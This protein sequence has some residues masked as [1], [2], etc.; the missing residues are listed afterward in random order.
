MLSD[1]LFKIYP[2]CLH[3]NLNQ[4]ESDN[5]VFCSMF[6]SQI[7]FK[8][9][10][11]IK[12]LQLE[13]E[14]LMKVVPDSANVLYKKKNT[15]PVFLPKTEEESKRRILQ[16]LAS[17]VM[18]LCKKQQ[19]LE[20]SEKLKNV[21]LAYFLSATPDVGK[22]LKI[23]QK[24][25]ILEDIL[26]KIN[27]IMTNTASDKPEEEEKKFSRDILF[28]AVRYDPL[29]PTCSGMVEVYKTGLMKRYVDV[30]RSCA[31]RKSSKLC[32]ST[33]HRGICVQVNL[34]APCPSCQ[35]VDSSA[36][37]ADRF[38]MTTTPCIENEEKAKMLLLKD[39][40]MFVTGR[41][42]PFIDILLK[43]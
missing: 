22:M 4:F 14:K 18:T 27:E 11:E 37:E 15:A 2:I 36:A 33:F 19:S 38:Q 9:D 24:G 42:W 31:T 10:A 43:R 23:K 6:L 13:K 25:T 39:P 5:V 21:D 8:M 29:C 7:I 16:S 20:Q 32:F 40:R 26:N 12:A 3:S 17:D 1:K 35:K 30:A 28:T 41:V 34:S